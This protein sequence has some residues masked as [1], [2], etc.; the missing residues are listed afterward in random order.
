MMTVPTTCVRQVDKA[1][2]LKDVF[3]N[4]HLEAKRLWPKSLHTNF[5][6]EGGAGGFYAFLQ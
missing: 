3:L 4:M 6:G 5:P 2:S 1:A